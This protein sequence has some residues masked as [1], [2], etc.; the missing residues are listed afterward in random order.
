[1]I[2]KQKGVGLIEVLIAV[3]VLAVGLVSPLQPR[4]PQVRG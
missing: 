3:L 4:S 1:M 2:K